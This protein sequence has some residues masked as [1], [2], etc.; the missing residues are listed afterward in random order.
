MSRLSHQ[1][2][3][4]PLPCVNLFWLPFGYLQEF[5]V[6]F[7]LLSESWVLCLLFSSPPSLF[8]QVLL[9]RN[10]PT[11]CRHVWGWGSYSANSPR[12]A[13]QGQN[14]ITSLAQIIGRRPHS[15]HF[16]NSNL[17]PSQYYYF[18]S[19]YRGGVRPKVPKP[20]IGLQIFTK[21]NNINDPL[22]FFYC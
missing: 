11:D 9:A 15:Q 2:G 6:D 12:P 17:C 18:S 5:P 7:L 10:I 16:D 22:E 8:S 14:S 3:Y 4:L 19:H 1:R 21:S 13:L 20:L